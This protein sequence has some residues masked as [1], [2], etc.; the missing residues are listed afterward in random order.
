MLTITWQVRAHRGYA[1]RAMETP[2]ANWKLSADRRETVLAVIRGEA[3]EDGASLTGVHTGHIAF[4]AESPTQP[5]PGASAPGMENLITTGPGGPKQPLCR[6]I[7]PCKCCVR[8]PVAHATGRGCAGPS[9]PESRNLK[10]ARR[11]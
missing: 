6:P 5:L 1:F 9:G 10:A 8:S 4:R 3:V 11:I 2:V 7:G